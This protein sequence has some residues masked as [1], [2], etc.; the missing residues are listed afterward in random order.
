M[1]NIMTNKFWWVARSFATLVIF[2]SVAMSQGMLISEVAEGSSNNKYIEI[3]NGTGADVDLSNYA[4][5][6]CSN[7]CDDS[8]AFD[9]PNNVTFDTGTTLGAGDVYVV[10]HPQA[11]EFIQG[12]C[13]GTH[14]YLSNGD[15]FYALVDATDGTVI[16]KVGDFGDDPGSGW[17]VGGVSNATKDHTLVRKIGISEGNLSLIHI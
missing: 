12:E 8:L 10:C 9:Y 6:S 7:G 4:L 17:D 11:D 2:G 1:K 5:S 13:D 16:D 3:Y 15:D 14:Q